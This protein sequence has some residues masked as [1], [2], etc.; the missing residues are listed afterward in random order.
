[1]NYSELIKFSKNYNQYRNGETVRFEFT[2]I[3]KKKMVD[4][5]NNTIYTEGLEAVVNIDRFKDGSRFQIY[6]AVG[7]HLEG[8]S[9]KAYNNLDSLFEEFEIQKDQYLA[10]KKQVHA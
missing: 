8:N 9:Q 7:H 5:N 3:P 10:I 1:M 2:V 4:K 6:R